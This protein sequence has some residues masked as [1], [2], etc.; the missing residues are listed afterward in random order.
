M[1]MSWLFAEVILN[2]VSERSPKARVRLLLAKESMADAYDTDGNPRH[3]ARIQSLTDHVRLK[4]LE[5]TGF[6]VDIRNYD[7]PASVSAVIVDDKI[8]SLSWYR[9]FPD[10]EIPRIR[11]HTSPTVTLDG[12]AAKTFLNFGR[13]QFNA[14]WGPD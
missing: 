11:G 6:K 5:K 9:V 14:L 2:A 8:I 4:E 3:S 10:G 7:T 12:A 13:E 1:W